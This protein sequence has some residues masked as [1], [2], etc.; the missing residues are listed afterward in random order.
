MKNNHKVLLFPYTAKAY[1]LIHMLLLNGKQIKVASYSGTGLVGHDIGYAI[2]SKDEG[3]IVDNIFNFDLE[4]IEELVILDSDF[5]KRNYHHICSLISSVNEQGGKVTILSKYINKQN[6]EL[7]IE[8]QGIRQYIYDIDKPIIFVAGI[9]DTVFNSITSLELKKELS[10]L[11]INCNILTFDP[12]LAYAGCSICSLDTLNSTELPR[13]VYAIKTNIQNSLSDLA[14][15]ALIIQI[16][17]G[18]IQS[19]EKHF[20]D[21]GIYYTLFC[22]IASP[23]YIICNLPYEYCDEATL[24]Q[25]NNI[26][27]YKTHNKGIDSIL[28]NNYYMKTNDPISLSANEDIVYLPKRD[29]TKNVDNSDIMKEILKENYQNIAIDILEKLGGNNHEC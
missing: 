25:L 9:Y 11:N 4:Q 2:N 5:D 29:L 14:V 7:N 23:D 22:D 8:E 27:K 3:L 6:K 10:K 16:P 28:F 1:P 13:A 12:N 19:N 26:I 24:I 20:N 17:G 15:D 21:F 18:I